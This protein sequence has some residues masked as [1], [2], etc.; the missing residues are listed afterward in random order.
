MLILEP[1][2]GS[3]TLCVTLVVF[4]KIAPRHTLLNVEFYACVPRSRAAAAAGGGCV[5]VYVCVQVCSLEYMHACA[6][7]V[8]V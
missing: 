1:Y 4:Y 5:R 8:Y 7:G 2:S 6:R 3:F